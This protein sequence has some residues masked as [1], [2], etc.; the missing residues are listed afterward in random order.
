MI[1]QI[2]WLLP[3]SFDQVTERIGEES[4]ECLMTR[5]S[6]DLGLLPE[7]LWDGDRDLLHWLGA[8]RKEP[9]RL[10]KRGV[11]R[12]LEF[13]AYIRRKLLRAVPEVVSEILWKNGNDFYGFGKYRTTSN[14]VLLELA[15]IHIRTVPLGCRVRQAERGICVS[16]A[17]KS[18]DYLGLFAYSQYT[19]PIDASAFAKHY[20]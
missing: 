8:G 20:E 10:R 6:H 1:V 14:G 17:S 15:K 5:P 11:F 13:D 19:T 18:L 3:G 16:S 9:N 7:V 4:R 12:N 2:E